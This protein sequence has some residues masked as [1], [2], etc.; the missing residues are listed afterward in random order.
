MRYLITFACYGVRLHGDESGSVDRLHN[1]AGSPVLE[2]RPGR[3][4]SERRL[5]DQ[6]PYSLDEDRRAGVLAAI[7]EVCSHREW[8]LL[9][10]HVRTSH[11]HAVVE[12]D[13]EPEK[14]M[15]DFKVYA[16]RR[17]N[18]TGFE[19][20]ARKRWARHGSTRWLWKDE[21]VRSAVRYVVEEQGEPM[22][23]YEA[24]II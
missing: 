15:A 20:P 10:A 13:V 14:I 23:V 7:L 17:L 16:S 2:A 11:V 19:D 21:D 3:V 1:Q 4:A 5:M 9:A 6:S 12:A 18:R 22:A 24:G 8:I